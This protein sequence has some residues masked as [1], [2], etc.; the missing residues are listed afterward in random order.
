MKREA[1]F[2]AK[3]LAQPPERLIVRRPRAS[4]PDHLR[5]RAHLV[6][7]PHDLPHRHRQHVRLAGPHQALV[8]VADQQILQRHPAARGRQAES[9]PGSSGSS[10]AGPACRCRS[11][12]APCRT[13]SPRAAPRAARG[14]PSPART[15]RWSATL[16][17]STRPRPRGP[18]PAPWRPQ[19]IP[20]AASTGTCPPTA[21]AISGTST[22]L[23]I[24][25]GCPPAWY[26]GHDDVHAAGH[27]TARVLRLPGQRR[28]QH[29]ALVGPRDHIRRGRARPLAISRAG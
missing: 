7:P 19:P 23:A 17:P 27:V 6:H 29:A 22:M 11:A 25:P 28:D 18:A 14:W 4:A 5:D 24:S 15:P 9:R 10:A 3:W 2:T 1:S 12:N 8:C 20:P 13:T 21:S 26:P 16:S